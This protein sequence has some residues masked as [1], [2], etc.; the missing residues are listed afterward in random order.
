MLFALTS[1]AATGD[2]GST[3]TSRR[4]R[5]QFSSH[6]ETSVAAASVPKTQ[7]VDTDYL[8]WSI[9]GP[10]GAIV[11]SVACDPLDPN[12]IYAA[13]RERGLY[14][15]SD[16]G[17]SWVNLGPDHVDAYCVAVHP[18]DTQTLF[19][20]TFNFGVL[21][22]TDGGL[23]WLRAND[24]FGLLITYCLTFDPSNPDTMFAGGAGELFRT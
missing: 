16:R 19:I 23:T 11:Y 9:N 21:K 4:D 6:H 10:C 22:S 12:V 5:D 8:N 7:D 18:V 14:K 24:G 17:A 15:S 13:T 1:S 2:S 3:L 20:G